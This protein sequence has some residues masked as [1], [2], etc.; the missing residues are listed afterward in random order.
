MS[1]SQSFLDLLPRLSAL[2]KTVSSLSAQ[3]LNNT[4]DFAALNQEIQI[5]FAGIADLMPATRD[6]INYL[7]M[8]S[9]YTPFQQRSDINTSTTVSALIIIALFQTIDLLQQQTVDLPF[10]IYFVGN[11]LVLLQNYLIVPDFQAYRA[12]LSN[13]VTPSNVTPS[14]NPSDP[15]PPL[16]TNTA[17]SPDLLNFEKFS[18][19]QV[20]NL[21][22][23]TLNPTTLN[24]PLTIGSIAQISGLTQVDINGVLTRPPVAIKDLSHLL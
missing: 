2:T 9:I 7:T 10:V 20:P 18:N 15:P 21:N 24:G 17:L 16:V 8:K 12:T 11:L 5:H 19:F 3:T 23:T 14:N 4:N 13:F 6:V 22:P 1:V